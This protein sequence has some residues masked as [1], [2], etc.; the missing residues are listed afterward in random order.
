MTCGGAVEAAQRRGRGDAVHLR[1]PDVHQHDIGPMLADGRNGPRPVVRLA[2]DLEVLGRGQ[3]DPEPGAHQRVV[4]DQEHL[5]PHHCSSAS[6]TKSP[7]PSGP[8]TRVPPARAT[9]SCSPSRP[10]PGPGQR[11]SGLR[12]DGL[13]VADADVQAVVRRAGDPYPRRRAAGVLADVGERLLHDAI[14]VASQRARYGVRVLNLHL[15][16]DGRAG[17]AGSPRRGGGCPTASAA[18]VAAAGSW[19]GSSRSSPITPRSSSRA[20]R[21][22]ERSSSAVSRTCSGGRSGRTS[23]A[24]ACNA[25]SEIRWAST[26]CISRAIRV[27][28]AIRARSS[29]STLVGL[30]PQ[31]PLAQGQEQL[32]SGPDEHPPARSTASTSGMT[33]TKHRQRVGRRAVDGEGQHGRNPQRRDQQRR[34]DRAVDGEGEQR[35]EPG[36]GGRDRER[37]QQRDRPAQRR[38][39][40]AAATRATMQASSPQRDVDDDLRGSA[41]GRRCHAGSG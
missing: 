31:G 35:E 25:S 27:R 40:N 12:V 32:A 4:V 21:A 28:S 6:T 2:H 33:R 8:C 16:V 5:H 13:A 10:G 20:W 38:A 37:P 36:R 30:R 15:E 1:H 18:E 3:D 11:R 41:T 14:G 23:S 26:S 7:E 39:A 29:C 17:A 24:P 19:P 22:V 34:P 9:R